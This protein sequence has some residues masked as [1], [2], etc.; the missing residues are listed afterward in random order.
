M[1]TVQR[2]SRRRYGLARVKAALD[3][4]QTAQLE[5]SHAQA[6]LSAVRGYVDDWRRLGKLY[7]RIRAEW[8]RLNTKMERPGKGETGDLDRDPTERDHNPHTTGCGHP[9]TRSF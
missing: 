3:H 4:I 9:E 7:E 1:T 8:Y 2:E 6:D 5:L